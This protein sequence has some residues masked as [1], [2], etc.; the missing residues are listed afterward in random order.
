MS[1]RSWKHWAARP[2]WRASCRW[3]HA[4]HTAAAWL[5]ATPAT[6]TTA[7]LLC[8]A[9][10]PG[11]LLC[12]AASVPPTHYRRPQE[13]PKALPL[14]FRPRDRH[15]HATYGAR[16]PSRRLL[17]KLS[18]P[19]GSE[20]GAGGEGGGGGSGAWAAEVVAA[21]PHSYRFA[22]PADFQYVGVDSRPVEEQGE[23]RGHMAWSVVFCRLPPG[24]RM[25]RVP[26]RASPRLP[27]ARASCMLRL[28]PLP[29]RRLPPPCCRPGAAAGRV[30]A[31]LCAAAAA[32]HAASV[33]QAASL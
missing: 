28:K 4:S 13:N 26:A 24:V 11:G 29:P 16:E 21:L 7:H 18:R 3:V 27:A 15:C 8:A 10:R 32:V 9:W 25:P 19:A 17:L 5:L 30:A 22:Q 33:C 14:K 23:G 2:G 12:R 31:R 20:G 1:R 6:Q